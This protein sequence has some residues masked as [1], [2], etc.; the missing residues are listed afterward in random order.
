MRTHAHL[1]AHGEDRTCGAARQTP[2]TDMLAE[3]DEQTINFYPI[4]AR[5]NFC[6]HGRRLFRSRRVY[7]P[8]AI[9]H[10]VYVDIDSDTRLIASDTEHEVGALR[11]NSMKRE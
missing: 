5:Q 6:E 11:S 7:I 1:A 2:G 9:R 10:T 3:R 4:G 8:P